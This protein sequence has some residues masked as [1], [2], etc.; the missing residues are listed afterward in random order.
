MTTEICD[1]YK[2]AFGLLL[3]FKLKHSEVENNCIAYK[4]T[5]KAISLITDHK[6]GGCRGEP[7]LRTVM[8]DNEIVVM[9]E[10]EADDFNLK[11]VPCEFYTKNY[12]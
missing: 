5:K 11:E 1:K 8:H 2:I 7:S 12:I 10:M 3:T 9:T 6:K 4:A